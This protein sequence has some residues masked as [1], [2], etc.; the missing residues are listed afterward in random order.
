[1]HPSHLFAKYESLTLDSDPRRGALEDTPKASPT[2][3]PGT[4]V[5]DSDIEG[6]APDHHGQADISEG[7]TPSQWSFGSNEFENNN[8]DNNQD[9]GFGPYLYPDGHHYLPE[10]AYNDYAGL[11]AMPTSVASPWSAGSEAS[12]DY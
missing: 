2:G 11:E 3:T 6:I 4:S 8:Q 10:D 7:H 1:M 12:Q 5:L 9:G